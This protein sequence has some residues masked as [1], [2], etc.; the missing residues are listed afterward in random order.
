MMPLYYTTSQLSI[1]FR[2]FPRAFFAL[3]RR[4]GTLQLDCSQLSPPHLSQ[5]IRLVQDNQQTVR[6][7]W[8]VG[9][10]SQVV[11]IGDDFARLCYLNKS[12][13]EPVLMSTT[14]LSANS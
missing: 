1:A 11:D 6:A 9:R 3:V 5:G 7:G 4:T 2:T 8:R 12:E 10:N 14:S 13:C